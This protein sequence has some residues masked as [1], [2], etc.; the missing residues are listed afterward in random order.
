MTAT[1]DRSSAA[2]PPAAP[3]E[4]IAHMAPMKRWLM[5]PEIG[6]LI[7][8]IAVWTFFWG[9][10]ETFGKASSTLNWLDLAAPTGIMATA[11]ALLMIGGEFDL[12]SGVMTGATAMQIGL[13]A[14]HFQGTGISV[15]WAIA[16][17]VLTAVAI[18]WFNGMMI[19]R[20]GL[21]S[22]IITL[23]TFWVVRGMVVVL[24]QRV[25]H[26]SL[27]DG[28][29]EVDGYAGAK[30]WIAHEWNL[31]NFTGR[32]VLFYGLLALGALLF[33]VGL[34]DQSF[35]RRASFNPLALGGAVVAL[36][37]AALGFYGLH[38]D[39]GVGANLGWG[40]CMLLGGTLTVVL[41]ALAFW[42]PRSSG[43][44]PRQNV[45]GGIDAGSRKR[46]VIG[47]ACLVLSFLVHIPFDRSERAPVLSW[48]APS[49]RVLLALA[50]GAVGLAMALL[51][52]LPGL[53]NDHS[54]GT[55]LRSTFA[56]GYGALVTG[57]LG[58]AVL[59]LTTVQALRFALM[60]SLAAAGLVLLMLTRARVAKVS[61]TAQFAVGLLITAGIVALAFVVRGDSGHR[62]FRTLL[63]SA[64]LVLAAVSLTNALLEY[65]M[66]KRTEGSARAD[67]LG[68]RA[69]TGG[70]VLAAAGVVLR[71]V[72]TNM[73]DAQVA[74]AKA[75]GGGILKNPLR[76][77]VV[78]WML[79]MVIGA[80]VLNKTKWGNWIYAVGGNKDAARAIGV[81]VNRVK[82]GLFVTVSVCAALSGTLIALRYKS[83]QANQGIGLELE[84]II[85]AVVGGSLLTGGFG[86]VIGAALGAGIIAISQ[87]GIAAANWNS[88]GRYAFLGGTLLIAVLVNNFTRKKA[89]EAR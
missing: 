1:T 10:A 51:R 84:Y 69:V 26:K 48:A 24:A 56:G 81:P 28:I 32:N 86:S 19:N 33:A 23:A 39:D 60:T 89:Q 36:A 14:K 8:A 63:F 52:I 44:V 66:T 50:F 22:F 43:A 45:L 37:V 40:L 42:T 55:I 2:P 9:V 13:M 25:E 65:L 38:H 6:A 58:V 75:A 78:W 49:V 20:T 5:T 57:A 41:L 87:V 4:R 68:R 17:T 72:W 35:I 62:R 21:P 46:L 34:L 77:T 18:G 12:S 27:V 7:G 79:V 29:G 61:H 82:I 80:Y 31:Q 64:I 70:A 3:D 76:E 54:T 16:V 88:D 30:Q 74:A 59:Q 11:V 47:V 83:V 85:A 71:I 53:K 15:F 67:K 73:T